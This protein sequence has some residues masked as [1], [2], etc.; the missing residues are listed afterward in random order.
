MLRGPFLCR[1]FSFKIFSYLS[2]S[3]CFLL[4]YFIIFHSLFYYASYLFRPLGIFPYFVAHFLNKIDNLIEFLYKTCKT[5]VWK[6]FYF[7][8]G[9]VSVMEKR[10]QLKDRAGKDITESCKILDSIGSVS[11]NIDY[12]TTKPIRSKWF[13]WNFFCTPLNS[14][15]SKY[16]ELVYQ[17]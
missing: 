2:T 10:R 17:K 7:S 11:I 5:K 3:S 6:K 15:C 16:I 14:D 13:G 8:S 1:T 4:L 9:I 12:V